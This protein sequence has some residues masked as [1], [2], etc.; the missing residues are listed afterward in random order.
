MP[1]THMFGHLIS[2]VALPELMLAHVMGHI[3]QVCTPDVRPLVQDLLPHGLCHGHLHL[4]QHSKA[5][6][7][8]SS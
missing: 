5:R 4:Q 3:G 6:A 1:Y 7:C 8:M 2:N